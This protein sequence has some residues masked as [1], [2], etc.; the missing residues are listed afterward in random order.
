M[1]HRSLYKL[2][3]V[4]MFL[5]VQAA[6]MELVCP[7]LSLST[8]VSPSLSQNE[9]TFVCPSPE[10]AWASIPRAQIKRHLRAILQS[11]GHHKPIFEVRAEGLVVDPGP[12]SRVN[13]I[14]FRFSG[15]SVPMTLPQNWKGRPIT[16]SLLNEI[17]R[18]SAVD[19]QN[20]AYPC[21]GARATVFAQRPGNVVVQVDT[22]AFTKLKFSD[23]E[24]APSL[25]KNYS[26]ALLSRYY[27]FLN[28]RPFDQQMLLLTAQRF[29]GTGLFESA[30]FI[31]QC[32]NGNLA[33]V[34]LR[35]TVG[36]PRLVRVGMGFDTEGIVKAR[37]SWRH[38]RL[39]AN[40]S[41]LEMMVLASRNRQELTSSMKWYLS[42]PAPRFYLMPVLSGVH[43]FE[44]HFE[45]F[46]LGFS[47]SPAM[48]FELPTGQL[49]LVLGPAFQKN[50]TV[51]GPDQGDISLL[52]LESR[53]V[54]LSHSLEFQAS[55]PLEG[56]SWQLSVAATDRAILSDVSAW[57]MRFF[58]RR[59]WN[60]GGYEPA[61]VVLGMRLSLNSTGHVGGKLPPDFRFYLG[62]SDNLRGFSRL[63]LPSNGLGA[64]SSFYVST[65]ARFAA[66]LPWGLQPLLFADVGAAGDSPFEF[67][68]PLY[69][70][71]GFGL[72]WSSPIGVFRATLGHGFSIGGS[73]SGRW[74]RPSHWQLFVGYGEEF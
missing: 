41:T 58:F 30:Y 35:G 48:T 4:L 22:G 40:A 1:R 70:S 60:I 9:K 57:R 45:S 7:G 3:I 51:R 19:L 63:E 61:R 59:L 55:D 73:T 53:M 5:G 65:E 16:P 68:S 72:R 42:T 56:T 10:S 26:S 11:R 64:L 37:A 50:F 62:G 71:P 2:L 66:L 38:V 34:S 74:G 36:L 52:M 14:E 29:E 18:S 25:K 69:V 23:I 27:A 39:G 6:A 67:H 49:E 46:S 8:R 33:R 12:V 43:Q 17:E 24:L 44:Q 13:E 31:P 28:N 54:Y 20:R 21:A 32:E 47:L 15:D